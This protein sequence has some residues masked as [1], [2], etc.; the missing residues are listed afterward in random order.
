MNKT[1]AFLLALTII[2]ATIIT[3]FLSIVAGADFTAT[4][5]GPMAPLSGQEPPTFMFV[6]ENG[7]VLK[8]HDKQ[9]VSI[10]GSTYTENFTIELIMNM[11][12]GNGFF[13][14]LHNVSYKASW[15]DE[16]VV[17]YKWSINDPADLYDDDPNGTNS[18][19]YNIVLTEIPEGP[20]HIDFNA[21]GGGIYI[22]FGNPNIYHTFTIAGLSSLYFTV[23]EEQEPDPFPTVSIAVASVI[24]VVI[25]AG[26]LVYFKKRKH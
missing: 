22:S 26:L 11:D 23:V 9:P 18:F 5:A 8:P 10:V 1:F 19:S 2:A 7:T 20:H 16:P 6:L 13:V 15:Q 4:Y 25:V 3:P 14:N 24:T 21:A 12:N 17:F